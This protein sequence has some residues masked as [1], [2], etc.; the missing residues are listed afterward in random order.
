MIY[1]NGV[2]RHVDPTP[3]NKDGLMTDAEML[4]NKALKGVGWDTNAY[5]KAE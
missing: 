5:P 2:W 3:T 4:T 1:L